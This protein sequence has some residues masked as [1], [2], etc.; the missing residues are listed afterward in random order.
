MISSQ[1]IA[2]NH[3]IVVSL[4]KKEASH[5]IHITATF[6]NAQ[7]LE[8]VGLIPGTGMILPEDIRDIG[9]WRT[10]D[11]LGWGVEN[12]PS[13]AGVVLWWIEDP[14]TWPPAPPQAEILFNDPV[15]GFAFSY[16]S[17]FEVRLDAFDANDLLVATVSGPENVVTGFNQWDPLGLDVGENVISRVVISGGA[18]ATMIDDMV[19]SR[20]TDL[21][22]ASCQVCGFASTNTIAIFTD[23]ELD[24]TTIDPAS[25]LVGDPGSGTG[26]VPTATEIVDV[27]EDGLD[28]LLLTLSEAEML[29]AGALDNYTIQLIIT[30]ETQA[31]PSGGFISIHN[32][33]CPPVLD[34]IGSKEGRESE[35]LQFT[36]TASDPD[37]GDILTFAVENLPD[38]ASFDSQAAT[39]SWTPEPGDAGSYQN[40][41]FTVMDDG[42]PMALDTERITITILNA[43]NPPV[44]DAVGPKTVTEYDTLEF[45]VSAIDPDEDDIISIIALNLPEGAAFNEE[46]GLFSW[47]PDGTQQ[48]EYTV[49]FLAEDDGTPILADQ[50]DI[51]ITV[52]DIT[53]PT[54]L[55]D[56]II[57]NILALELPK[58]VE[59]AYLANINRVNRFIEK[60]K[61]KPAIRQLRSFI[62]K[63]RR[64]IA[65]AVLSQE[66][67]DLFIMMARD[68]IALLRSSR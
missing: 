5:K 65:R 25:I 44:F 17:L 34:P 26:I 57:E 52:N 15:S 42:N 27:N 33:N 18:T 3:E 16:A 63:I 53:S 20:L 10:V 46:S 2:Q 50:I 67:G 32:L 7:S 24:A 31:T 12:N 62:R 35:L 68:E 38:G 9:A 64:G 11:T 37:E 23:D 29:E 58:R 6:E 43:N 28:D 54:D 19:L 8:P 56:T 30:G 61:V 66:D 22:I 39:F 41:V 45:Y 59:N 14:N 47:R 55:S 21:D 48:G 49:S 36:I 13:G 51:T 4:E 40:V 1:A 60:G